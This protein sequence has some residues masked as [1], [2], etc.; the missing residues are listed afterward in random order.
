MIEQIGRALYQS[1]VTLFLGF[2]YHQQNFDMLKIPKSAGD[3]NNYAGRVY[4]TAY[5]IEQENYLRLEAKMRLNLKLSHSNE[6]KV[7]GW[8]SMEL[9]EKMRPS[10]MD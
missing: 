6:V 1:K 2:G 9:I 4:A 5:K 3:G 10:I 8:R 7:L